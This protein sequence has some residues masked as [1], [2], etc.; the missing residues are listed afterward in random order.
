VTFPDH[1]TPTGPSQTAS[2]GTGLPLEP[3][4]PLTLRDM[5]TE[6]DDRA[7]LALLREIRDDPKAPKT[8]RLQAATDLLDRKHGKAK[9][10]IET[11]HKMQTLAD[12]ADQIREREKRFQQAVQQGPQIT[13]SDVV[14]AE[15][16]QLVDWKSLL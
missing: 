3:Q 6:D 10:F 4:K 13:V 5:I 12:L 11:E 8:A 2:S 14:D 9:Q 1:T 15:V 16:K 7:N